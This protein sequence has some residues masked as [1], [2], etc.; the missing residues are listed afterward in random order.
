[1]RKPTNKRQRLEMRRNALITNKTYDL[2]AIKKAIQA[3]LLEEFGS[4]LRFSGDVVNSEDIVNREGLPNVTYTA[5]GKI[6]KS[7]VIMTLG[8]KLLEI[9]SS[10]NL[11]DPI[12]ELFVALYT[13]S[14]G[15]MFTVYRYTPLFHKQVYRKLN[16]AHDIWVDVGFYDE[17]R[18]QRAEQMKP[19]D[20]PDMRSLVAER[21]GLQNDEDFG[22]VYDYVRVVE[23]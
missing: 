16:Q 2:M 12:R 1:M 3:E 19:D 13:A 9:T 14:N 8:G 21:L 15:A 18:K 22:L 5:E 7:G 4:G 10:Q 23:F 17:L 6:A 11:D 20:V